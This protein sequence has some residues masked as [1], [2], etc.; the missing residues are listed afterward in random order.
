MSTFLQLQIDASRKVFCSITIKFC[1]GAY[2]SIFKNSQTIVHV[3]HT[4]DKAK[5]YSINWTFVFGYYHGIPLDYFRWEQHF[6]R[7]EQCL[8][9]YYST[10]V[11]SNNTFTSILLRSNN[12]F[13]Q[14]DIWTSVLGFSQKEI[15]YALSVIL[16]RV[17]ILCLLYK[18]LYASL[19]Y[20]LKTEKSA[21]YKYSRIFH[22]LSD[23][24]LLQRCTLKA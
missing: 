17:H 19:S 8:Q 1:D 2:I 24:T 12:M 21:R 6:K 7:T 13:L 22:Q 4:I 16:S 18:R 5:L 10:V 11:L 9:C 14:T 3:S 23:S 15:V 20:R